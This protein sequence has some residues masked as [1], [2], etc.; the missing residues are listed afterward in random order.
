MDIFDLTGHSPLHFA[1]YKNHEA[2]LEVLIDFVLG[3]RKPSMSVEEK[4]ERL[5]K[6]KQWVNL[7]SKGEEGFTALHFASFHGNM[8]MIK[9][10]TNYG[11]NVHVRN[12]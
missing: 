1:A 8:K 11:A 7:K 5:E 10:L 4:L 2:S 12:R 9:I 6:L 3:R